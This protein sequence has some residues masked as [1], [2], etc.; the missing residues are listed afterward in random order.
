MKKTVKM[1]AVACA[2]A[3]VTAGCSFNKANT[4]YEKAQELYQSGDYEEAAQYFTRAIEQKEDRAEY[5][6]EYGFT[7]IQLKEY[8]AAIAQ[9]ES[10]VMDKNIP[11]VLQ[12][13]KQAYRGIGIAYFTMQDYKSATD[14]FEQALQISEL[15][16]L[17]TDIR[18]YIASCYD[19]LARYDDAIEAYTELIS[20]DSK[21]AAL[22][23]ARGNIYRK[24]GEYESSIKDY[25]QALTY[26]SDNFDV[27]FGA[28]TAFREMGQDAKAAEVLEKASLIKMNTDQDKL[29][30]GKVHFYQNN[31][32]QCEVE[33][34]DALSKG[35]TEANYYLGEIALINEEYETALSYFLA[36]KQAGN[37][38]SATF[39]NQLTVC[40][41]QLNDFENAA[42]MLANA[43]SYA[44]IAIDQQL[45]RNEIIILENTG[46]FDGALKL[47]EKYI[48]RYGQDE[49][50]EKDYLFLQTRV[51]S[52]IKDTE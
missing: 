21:N 51:N 37:T 34:N 26:A 4:Y 20:S 33:F 6:L 50:V 36:Y 8:D 18:S 46:D 2:V 42:E 10:M 29:D 19:N 40:Y 28:Y 49:D 3:M 27:Y 25:E 9:F 47:M 7:L 12:N 13:N 17:N 52:N 35:L 23:N 15:S 38:L 41:I 30:L 48:K 14:Y 11:M 24:L 22:Y 45:L 31:Y 39:F 43:K 32:E 5:R 16:E 44:H 1:A